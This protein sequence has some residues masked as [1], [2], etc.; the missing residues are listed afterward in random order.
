MKAQTE[1]KKEELQTDGKINWKPIVAE[2]GVVV[3]RGLITGFT[4]QA[5]IMIFN[6]SLG[7]NTNNLLLIEGGKK[8]MS[9]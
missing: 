6:K 9:A 4:M 2:L 1:S 8:T 7:R 3:L 5:G